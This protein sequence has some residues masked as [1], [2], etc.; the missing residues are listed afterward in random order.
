MLQGRAGRSQARI[1]GTF[2]FTA[3]LII[4]CIVLFRCSSPSGPTPPTPPPVV[5]PPPVDPAPNPPTPTPAP[6]PTPPPVNDCDVVGLNQSGIVWSVDGLTLT[7]FVPMSPIRG[8]AYI[9]VW[10]PE[11][12][13]T[14]LKK[15]P[16]NVECEVELPGYGEHAI[17]L[18]A[19]TKDDRVY[20]CDRIQFDV[21]AT[22]PTTT[23]TTRPKGC[24]LES[25]CE[26]FVSVMGS[27][28]AKAHVTACNFKGTVTIVGTKKGNPNKTATRFREYN[29]DCTCIEDDVFQ[30]DTPWP[31][32]FAALCE[33]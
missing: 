18:A 11:I 26:V 13:H 27:R 16:A 25:F 4:E 17:R 8:E 31:A 29:L 14:F 3:I 7:L 32:T 12:N 2:V 23:T 9:N 20:Q 10:T 6:I 15:C 19:E 33:P 22:P 28:W 5:N 21:E 24:D 1:L 30:I